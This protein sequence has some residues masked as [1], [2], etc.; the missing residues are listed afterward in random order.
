MLLCG[1]N[2]DPVVFYFNTALMQ[3]YWTADSAD[4]AVW[5][6]DVDSPHPPG[7]PF[8]SVKEDFS[9]TKKLLTMVEGKSF[10]RDNYHDVIVPAFCVQAAKQFF[11]LVLESQ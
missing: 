4:N 2:A 8:Q 10:V 11:D 5:Y 3:R 6:L 1:G 7:D 9:A